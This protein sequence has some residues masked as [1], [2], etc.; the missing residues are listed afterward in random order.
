MIDNALGFKRRNLVNHRIDEADALVEVGGQ[1]LTLLGA[2]VVAVVAGGSDGLRDLLPEF[3]AQLLFGGGDD[4]GEAQCL[5]EEVAFHG[6]LEVERQ[7][8]Q[9]V[10]VGAGQFGV[11]ADGGGFIFLH[12][13]RKVDFPPL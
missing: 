3:V 8:D 6:V 13:E 4:V 7:F 1:H 10:V 5:H 9:F 2:E 11:D 12:I